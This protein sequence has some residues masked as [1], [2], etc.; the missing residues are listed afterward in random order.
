[1]NEEKSSQNKI[2]ALIEQINHLELIMRDHTARLHTIEKRLGIVSQ[3]TEPKIIE[4][5]TVTPPEIKPAIKPDTES[6][7]VPSQ[8]QPTKN[9]EEWQS[10][11]AIKPIESSVESKAD[12]RPTS[13]YEPL[14]SKHEEKAK[15]NIKS[16]VIEEEVE[17][18]TVS[19]TF[20]RLREDLESRIGGNWFNKIGV[21]AIAI[22]IAFFLKYAIDNEIGPMGRVSIGIL[23]GLG[24]LFGAEK[25]R[26]KGYQNYAHG[27]SGGG[28]LILYLSVYAAN[29]FYQ[30]IS[31]EIAFLAMAMIT[32]V[33]VLLSARYNA[34]PIAILGLIGGFITPILLSRGVDNEVG[35]FTYIALL[36][37]GVLALAFYKQWRSLNYL[38]YI[39]TVL[40]ATGWYDR[41]YTPEKLWPTILFFTLFFVLFALIAILHNTIKRKATNWLDISLILVNAGLYFGSSYELLED[42]YR[43]FLGLF[44]LIVAAFYLLLGNFALRRNNEDRLLIYTFIGLATLFVTLAVPI[45]LDYL[46]VTMAWAVEGALLTWIGLKVPDRTARHT[47]L[48]LFGVAIVHWFGLDMPQFGYQ[49]YS[50]F[51]PFLNHR[52][53]SCASLVGSL[54]VAAWLYKRFGNITNVEESSLFSSIFILMA[55]ILAITL[56]TLDVNDYFE[57]KKVLAQAANSFNEVARIQNSKQFIFSAQWTIYATVAL[58]I[59]ILRKNQPVRML[60]ALLLMVA[61]V[62]VLFLDITY[63][64]AIWHTPIF[65]QTFTAFM[66]LVIAFAAIAK[67]YSKS[68]DIDEEERR[69]M[70][71]GCILLSN[72]LAIVGLSAEILGYFNKTIAVIDSQYSAQ[73]GKLENSKQLLLTTLWTIYPTITLIIGAIRKNQ[74]AR[75]LSSLLLTAAVIK[76]LV[77]DITFYAAAWHI[78]IFNQTFAAFMLL[79]IAFAAI[80]KTYSKNLDIDEQ[81][82]RFVFYSC[83]LLFNLFAIIGLSAEILGYFNRAIAAIAP[84]YTVQIG[85]LKNNKQLLLTALW[86][87]YGTVLLFFGIK[88]NIKLLRAFGLTLFTITTVKVLIFDLSY[89]AA[90]WHTPIFN[91]TFGAFSILIAGIASTIFLYKRSSSIDKDELKIVN[92]LIVVANILAIIALSAE[93]YGYYESQLHN[94]NLSSIELR[95]LYLKQRLSLSIIW[96]IYGGILLTIGL[97]RHNLILRYMA[98]ILLGITILKVFLIDLS[99]L[100]R[101]YRIVS[102]IVLGAILLLVSFL[103]QKLVTNEQ[104]K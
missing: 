37:T 22:G 51:I 80:A 88:R 77:L 44:A 98:L 15:E 65:N 26:D 49:A 75:I 5:K 45:Q 32:T 28:I 13:K 12:Q 20:N 85:N 21:V 29:G 25:L 97:V 90:T 39:A 78:P 35:L 62:K 73:I 71:Y 93:P 48:I 47:A 58:I 72:A 74:L 104:N 19:E 41:W 17:T 100:D 23:I 52:A 43:P 3:Y 24:F 99:S 9:R 10:P 91:Q 84:Q 14:R 92:L 76:V 79:V 89:Y 31:H 42:R 4:P 46:W 33:A 69:I 68:L 16:E 101:I 1:M 56:L 103:Y 64:A 54:V 86:S 40:M 27:I 8:P 102:F 2:D 81:E 96:T 63:Y 95:D 60:S 70:L 57:Q 59:G 6:L 67:A 82:K 7:T 87:I 50:H 66:L 11:Y 30:L 55:N 94:T 53:I 38:A 18:E 83:I 36:D 61:V 34:L